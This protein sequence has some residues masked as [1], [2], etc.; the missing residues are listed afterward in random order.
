MLLIYQ[1]LLKGGCGG[2]AQHLPERDIKNVLCPGMWPQGMYFRIPISFWSLT[3]TALGPPHHNRL[4]PQL[5]IR[6]ASVME[7]YLAASRV[8]SPPA[9]VHVRLSFPCLTTPVKPTPCPAPCSPAPPRPAVVASGTHR[10]KLPLQE[11]VLGDGHP[12]TNAFCY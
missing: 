10:Q 3:D 2:A 7:S 8:L 1:C 9:E 5:T 11:V 4:F 12:M 6:E